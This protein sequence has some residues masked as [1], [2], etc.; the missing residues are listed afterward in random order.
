MMKRWHE[1]PFFL[2]PVERQCHCHCHRQYCCCYYEW[3]TIH[4]RKHNKRCHQIRHVDTSQRLRIWDI[5][6]V[7]DHHL[8]HRLHC[9]SKKR[10]DLGSREI[11]IPT[12]AGLDG[13]KT[14]S[15]R[16]E[17]NLQDAA[18]APLP[19]HPRNHSPMPRLAKVPR[20]LSKNNNVAAVSI[21]SWRFETA[22]FDARSRPSLGIES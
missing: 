14:C 6:E 9:Q 21:E 5:S 3:Q 12:R 7:L 8:R 17:R 22:R 10:D 2:V 11:P 20:R 15:R 16:D 13:E 19:F 18:G 1:S 4:C